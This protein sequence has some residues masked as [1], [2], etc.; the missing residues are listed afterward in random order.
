[1]PATGFARTSSSRVSPAK[2][3]RTYGQEN[4]EAL[5]CETVA[6]GN[7][8]DT[9]KLKKEPLYRNLFREVS[10]GV[11]QG[12]LRISFQGGVGCPRDEVGWVDRS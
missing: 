12:K 11:L 3:M 2:V 5:V 4:G 8:T 6:F 9:E 10:M 1:M 7:T